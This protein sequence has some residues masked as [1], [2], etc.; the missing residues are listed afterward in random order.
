[1]KPLVNRIFLCGFLFFF[2]LFFRRKIGEI[3]FQASLTRADIHSDNPILFL[4]NHV[5]WW[6]GFV[7]YFLSRRLFPRHRFR[8]AMG[9]EEW[10]KRKWMGRLGVLPV[11]P[12]SPSQLLW[13]FRTMKKE[14]VFNP[15]I[16]VGYFFEG[17]MI[18]PGEA[19]GNALRGTHLLAKQ[20]A[21][22]T[23]IPVAIFAD[24]QHQPKST[25]FLRTGLPVEITTSPNGLSLLPNWVNE[26]NQKNIKEAEMAQGN[27]T[28]LKSMGWEKL[29]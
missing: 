24:V 18:V 10:S 26:L 2:R 11:E 6:D 25:L 12:K 13:F 22:V 5:S 7:L 4:A 27:P 14:R 21:P 23:V 1:M 16:C 9:Y 29:W 8:L 17:K 19:V 3:N 20:M 28:I 15:S